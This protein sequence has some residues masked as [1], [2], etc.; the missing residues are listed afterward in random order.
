MA[1]PIKKPG[2]ARLSDSER[3]II[4]AR[5]EARANKPALVT[6]S[7]SGETAPVKNPVDTVSAPATPAR[8]IG[9][10]QLSEAARAEIVA[11]RQANEVEWAKPKPSREK[12]VPA[13][14]YSSPRGSTLSDEQ[15]AI[16]VARRA[17][18]H[19]SAPMKSGPSREPPL[20]DEQKA[21]IVARREQAR[22]VDL[23]REHSDQVRQSRPS[24]EPNDALKYA[25]G[26][27]GKLAG[28]RRS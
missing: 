17:G 6:A 2:S 21:L 18:H 7:V 14:H 10:V 26:K 20:S 4:V 11:R 8:I 15:K 1:P 27:T 12:H 5:R 22:Q 19:A 23:S 13:K 24:R 25:M 3:A 28:G 9:H 16:I